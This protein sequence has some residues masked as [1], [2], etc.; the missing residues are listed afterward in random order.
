MSYDLIMRSCDDARSSSFFAKDNSRS[1]EGYS[2]N[3]DDNLQARQWQVSHHDPTTIHGK[4][5]F[6]FFCR[7]AAAAG[8]QNRNDIANHREARGLFILSQSS[9]SSGLAP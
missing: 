7:S 4:P 8:E 2:T 9:I 3:S 6:S 1:P 5:L